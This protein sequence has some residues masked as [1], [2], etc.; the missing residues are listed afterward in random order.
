MNFSIRPRVF[1]FFNPP[2]GAEVCTQSQKWT[3][4]RLYKVRYVYISYKC[5][6]QKTICQCRLQSRSESFLLNKFHG[7]IRR[8]Y[9][10]M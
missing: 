10:R 7:M 5:V 8:G 2:R 4:S 3:T 6:H 1:L 9:K